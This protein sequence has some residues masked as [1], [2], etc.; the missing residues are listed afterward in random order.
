[1]ATYNAGDTTYTNNL[2]H[3]GAAREPWI[4]FA[5]DTATRTVIMRT[6][7]PHI[8]SVV[9]AVTH[10]PVGHIARVGGARPWLAYIAPLR[11]VYKNM[12]SREANGWRAN[13]LEEAYGVFRHA[14]SGK[15]K[16]AWLNRG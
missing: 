14:M 7:S 1:M 16:A 11:G 3:V 13:S 8:Y 5:K 15:G 10:A 2:I 9:D 4:P 12:R 6:D